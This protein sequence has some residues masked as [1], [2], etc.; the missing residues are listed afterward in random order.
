VLGLVGRSVKG[1]VGCLTSLGEA[2][3]VLAASVGTQ[4]A[5]MFLLNTVLIFG[6]API[7]P[8]AMQDSGNQ[9]T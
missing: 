5:V 6:A 7:E 1:L 2:V 9:S 8:V 3:L 4:A